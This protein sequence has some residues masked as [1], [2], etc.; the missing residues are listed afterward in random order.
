MR[1]AVVG[2]GYVGLVVGACLAENGNEVICVDNNASKVRSLKRGR[3]PIYEPGLKDRVEKVRGKNLFFSI[4]VDKEIA[5]ADIIFVSV[6]TPT[7]TFGEGAGKAVDL[8]YIEQTARR[9]KK[10]STSPKI[11]IAIIDIRILVLYL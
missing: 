7:K 5:E 9:I 8:Q 10:N 3:I 11:V 2:T 4:E 6:N 1:I